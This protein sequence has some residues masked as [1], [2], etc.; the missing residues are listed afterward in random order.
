MP[1]PAIIQDN[2]SICGRTLEARE[3]T[4][5]T[6]KQDIVGYASQ[7]VGYRCGNCGAVF[8]GKG[9]KK[10]LGFKF[11]G[12]GYENSPCT[13]CGALL[14]A[15]RVLIAAGAQFKEQGVL[16]QYKLEEKLAKHK[17]H[18]KIFLYWAGISTVFFCLVMFPLLLIVDPD[19][20]SGP[21]MAIIMGLSG[22]GIYAWPVCLYHYYQKSKVQKT[23]EKLPPP[24]Q[25]RL[26]YAIQ[27]YEDRK[28]ERLPPKPSGAGEI[29]MQKK[30]RFN[31][32][33]ALFGL[34]FGIIGF[35][36]Y[37][38]EYNKPSPVI[39]M[40]LTPEGLVRVIPVSP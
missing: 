34:L 11:F 17:K 21:A 30:K 12:G 27:W 37:L 15:G 9:H 4:W 5:D 23:L 2:C 7:I 10:E 1:E 38:Q 22:L 14:G 28:W 18:T 36:F 31:I 40:E 24:G 25:G 26:Q 13:R 29:R 35:L 39:E 8:C 6:Y 19:A 20:S 33:L 3:I 16:F 32:L